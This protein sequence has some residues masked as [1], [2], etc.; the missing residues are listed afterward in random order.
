LTFAEVHRR[1]L[2]V[3]A[4]GRANKTEYQNF[5]PGVFFMSQNGNG[6]SGGMRWFRA[7]LHIHTPASEDYAEPEVTF[8]DILQEAERRGLDIIAFTDHNTVRG[9][10]LMRQEIEFLQ[11]LERQQRITRR[12]TRF[13]STSTGVYWR[14]LRFCRGLNSHR[15]MAR[16]FWESLLLIARS[17]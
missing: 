17:V 7:D 1:T 4:Q 16:T 2:I 3:L 14:I 12:G 11:T 5:S 8:L 13:V 6:S 15:T 9:Y 10:E